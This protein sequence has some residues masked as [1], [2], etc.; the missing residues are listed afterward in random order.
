MDERLGEPDA[1]CNSLTACAVTVRRPDTRAL[2]HGRDALFPPLAGTPLIRATS[3]IR[4]VMSDTGGC[5]E[6]TGA[7]LRGDG[8]AN[9]AGH[10]RAAFRRRM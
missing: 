7:P 8:V 3:H 2:H 9:V 1:A 5:Q 10:H 4:A 6:G